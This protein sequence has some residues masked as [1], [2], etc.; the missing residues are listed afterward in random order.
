MT[1]PGANCMEVGWRLA[2]AYWGQGYATEAATAALYFAFS[3]LEQD[4]V[5]AFTTVENSRSRKRYVETGNGKSRGEFSSPEKFQKVA[6]LKERV[7]YE[8]SRERLYRGFQENHVAIS[9][10]QSP[11]H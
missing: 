10:Q 6:G 2:K 1:L 4:W 7:Y 8:I 11:E 5:A 3:I 9:S